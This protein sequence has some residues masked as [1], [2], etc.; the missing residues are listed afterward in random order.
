MEGPGKVGPAHR[1]GDDLYLQL[2]DLCRCN[3]GGLIWGGARVCR[4]GL[5]CRIQ[6]GRC[7]G[8]PSGLLGAARTVQEGLDR[9]EVQVHAVRVKLTRGICGRDSFLGVHLQWR[10]EW[11]SP[12]LPQ[13]GLERWHPPCLRA[14][15]SFL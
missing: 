11:L 4:E 6:A 7:G 13:P 10:G 14:P 12:L 15:V 5:G 9:R 2:G 3:S 1:L 8:A